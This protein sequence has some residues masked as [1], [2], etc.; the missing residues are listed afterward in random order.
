MYRLASNDCTV[1]ERLHRLPRCEAK[2]CVSIDRAVVP[3]SIHQ[4]I[5]IL[6][7]EILV[8]YCPNSS[9]VLVVYHL[10]KKA[11]RGSITAKEDIL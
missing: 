7:I 6:T 1:S 4:T 3:S 8:H 9:V 5:V 2:D 10:P 11:G